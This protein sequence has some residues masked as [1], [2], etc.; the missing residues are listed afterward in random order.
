MWE[1]ANEYARKFGEIIGYKVEHWVGDEPGVCCFGDAYF[2]EL[3]EMMDVVDRIDEHCKRYGS[4][5]AVG[6]EVIDWADWLLDCNT[7]DM[8][9]EYVMPRVTRQLRPNI[10]LSAWLDG[11]PHIEKKAWTGPDSEYIQL[12]N[13]VETMERLIKEYRGNRTM[14]N[15]LTNLQA[16]LDIEAKRKAERDFKEWEEYI[17]RGVSVAM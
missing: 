7:A 16:R 1:V 10:C 17:K 9:K 2:F 6:Q 15:V 8:V 4:K 11:C 14:E 5:E 13:D 3:E 12:Q